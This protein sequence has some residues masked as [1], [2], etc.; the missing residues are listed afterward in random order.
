[1]LRLGIHRQINNVKPFVLVKLIRPMGV[2]VVPAQRKV[3]KGL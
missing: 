1:M 2:Q 3:K